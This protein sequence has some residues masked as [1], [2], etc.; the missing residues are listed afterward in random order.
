M[1]LHGVYSII[2]IPAYFLLHCNGN[3]FACKYIT[4]TMQ[5]NICRSKYRRL[6]CYL[7]IPHTQDALNCVKCC[8]CIVIQ[9]L[10][11]NNEKLM[12]YHNKQPNYL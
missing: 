3:I 8:Q 5:K 12:H 6:I 9:I 1:R 4:I 2:Y 10:V 11:K 7:N